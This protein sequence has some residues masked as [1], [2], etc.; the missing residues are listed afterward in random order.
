MN[1]MRDY[2]FYPDTDAPTFN[3]H[4]GY[5]P[6]GFDLSISAPQGTIYYTLDGSDPRHWRGSRHECDSV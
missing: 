3:Q 2:G 1:E 4:G 6:S 5:V